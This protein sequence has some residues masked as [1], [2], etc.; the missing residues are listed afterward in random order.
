M[1]ELVDLVDDFLHVRSLLRKMGDASD[2]PI[3]PKE[4]TRLLDTCMQVPGVVMAGVPGGK[5][6][7]FFKKNTRIKR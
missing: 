4:Q 3:E 6:F 7:F 5:L 1:H 2:V